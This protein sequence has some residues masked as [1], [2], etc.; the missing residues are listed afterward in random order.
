VREQLLNLAR[1]FRSFVSERTEASIKIKLVKIAFA[2]QY[3]LA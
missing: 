3:R 2:A 1:E